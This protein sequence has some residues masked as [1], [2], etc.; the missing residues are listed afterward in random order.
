MIYEGNLDETTGYA[1]VDLTVGCTDYALAAHEQEGSAP[2]ESIVVTAAIDT[3]ANATGI[4]DSVVYSGKFHTHG[5]LRNVQG[6]L[7]QRNTMIYSVSFSLEGTP[8][9]LPPINREV[10]ALKLPTHWNHDAI[11]DFRSLPGEFSIN[12]KTNTFKIEIDEAY[13]L[14]LSNKTIDD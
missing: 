7:S 14:S 13:W 1:F 8:V 4:R 3:C 10:A 6:I 9:P 2:P 5:D 11:I 12:P